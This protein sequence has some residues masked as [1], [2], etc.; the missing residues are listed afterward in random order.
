MHKPLPLVTFAV[1]SLIAAGIVHTA[2]RAFRQTSVAEQSAPVARENRD[3]ARIS[4]SFVANDQP[5]AFRSVPRFFYAASRGGKALD[6][7]EGGGNPFASS[8]VELLARE[9]LSFNDFVTELSVRT[10]FKSGGY[11]HPELPS[12]PELRN[13]VIRPKVPSESRVALVMVFSD[14]SGSRDAK[15]LPGARRDAMRVSA[16]LR[17][18]GFE[19]EMSID[20]ARMSVEPILRSFAVRSK[21]ADVAVLYT[22]GHGSEINGSVY[23][24]PGNYPMMQ[25][26][27]G[28]KEHA[29]RVSDL[30]SVMNGKHANLIFYAGCRD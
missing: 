1:L 4:D 21:G 13:W 30:S 17:Q 29:I 28:L 26:N 3:A 7:G 24:F 14:Y 8:L 10:Q 11:Q 25:E 5:G 27:E 22:T 16:A 9:S 6:Q 20:P 12:C 2:N 18:A 19:T 23:L 15:S